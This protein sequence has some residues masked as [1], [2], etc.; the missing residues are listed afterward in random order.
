MG[1]A[2]LIGLISAV[3]SLARLLISLAQTRGWID[4]GA[5]ETALKALRESDD[6]VSRAQAARN[7]VR[8]NNERDPASVLR[9]DDGFRRPGD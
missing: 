2:T 7:A 9:D 5:A 3:L 8:V 6:A 4:Q 1:A